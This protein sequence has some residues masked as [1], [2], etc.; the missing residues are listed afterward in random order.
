MVPSARSR[1][2]IRTTSRRRLLA[3]TGAGLATALAGCGDLRTRT[4][5][6]PETVEED[7]QTH[8]HFDDGDRRTATISLVDRWD[9]G[10]LPYAIRLPAWHAADTYLE[11]LRY[12][13][14]PLGGAGTPE[15]SLTRPGGYPWEPI[16]FARGDDPEVTVIAVPELG[17][18]GRGSVAFDLLVE[19]R[20][21]EA[22]EL[23][24]DVAATVESSGV[25][26]RTYELEG[27]LVRT[28]PGYDRFD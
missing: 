26:G 8:L 10:R 15:F 28:L 1:R 22:F 14:R 21:D 25:L 4:L 19:P 18:Q 24:L 16:E 6:R 12:E 5:D 17:V 20:N 2:S 9:A 13:L 27:N 3:A 11:R 23:R 7:G